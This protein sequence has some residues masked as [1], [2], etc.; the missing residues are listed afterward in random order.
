MSKRTIVAIVA[1]MVLL[2]LIAFSIAFGLFRWNENRMNAYTDTLEEPPVEVPLKAYIDGEE[3][4]F[5]ENMRAYG[6]AYGEDIMLSSVNYPLQPI[7]EKLG[8]TMEWDSATRIATVK[9]GDMTISLPADFT[10]FTVTT[11]HWSMPSEVDA[12]RIT[13]GVVYIEG[14][15]EIYTWIADDYEFDG[16][17]SLHITSMSEDHISKTSG[18]GKILLNGEELELPEG[19]EVMRY[20]YYG[21]YVPL[22]YVMEKLGAT[23]T[24]DEEKKVAVVM[25]GDIK[26]TVNPFEG[27]NGYFVCEKSG[28]IVKEG[29][30]NTDFK[31]GT[32]YMDVGNANW[33]ADLMNIN[34]DY[35]TDTGTVI[36][37][38]K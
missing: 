24:W 27:Y 3:L 30:E 20:D 7:V 16:D 29:L 5:P 4:A 6:L 8:G 26:I 1:V 13:D 28:K 23:M 2:S 15:S 11:P 32:V 34:V 18:K 19:L 9:M 31:D 37:E 33:L 21:A 22:D 36:I 38:T 17:G 14:F 35:D 12:Y 10:I 25:Y